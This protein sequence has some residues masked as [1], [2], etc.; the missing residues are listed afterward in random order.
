MSR[1]TALVRLGPS[2]VCFVLCERGFL[3]PGESLKGCVLFL[4]VQKSL[5]PGYRDVD[6][7]IY[8]YF[9]RAILL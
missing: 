3:H 6:L 7:C 8:V 4:L 2:V 1:M 5:G 9:S